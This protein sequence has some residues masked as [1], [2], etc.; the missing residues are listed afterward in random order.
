[1]MDALICFQQITF[2]LPHTSLKRMWS[3][4]HS[5]NFSST[6]AQYRWHHYWAQK[7][8]LYQLCLAVSVTHN[9]SSPAIHTV[10]KMF[11]IS[12]SLQ[13]LYESRRYSFCRNYG[14][15]SCDTLHHNDNTNPKRSTRR[16]T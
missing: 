16:L 12:S 8:V 7:P 10:S 4:Y 13:V 1:M 9:H 5:T 2:H 11:P 14:N 3:P 15:S 6:I